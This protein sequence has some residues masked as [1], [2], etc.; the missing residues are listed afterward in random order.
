VQFRLNGFTYNW[1]R[2]YG[3]WKD[4]RS[5][6]QQY[7]HLYSESVRPVSVTRLALRYINNLVFPSPFLDFGEYL[8]AQPN[9]PPALPQ[10][11]AQFLTRITLFEDQTSFNATVTEAFEGVINP[12][13]LTIILD[14]DAF[15]H[16]SFQ[17]SEYEIWRTLDGL[18]EFKNR[19]FFESL[20]EH[21]VRLFE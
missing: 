4:L 7:W 18:R 15:S 1:L 2:P 20:T 6:A 19:I 5:A 3:T 8:V 11:L 12:N 10:K 21:A 9:I 14:I 16:R 17:P 13:E